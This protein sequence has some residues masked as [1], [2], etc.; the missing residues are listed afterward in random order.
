MFYDYRNK[1][2][3]YFKNLCMWETKKRGDHI[4]IA[5]DNHYDIV[6]YFLLVFSMHI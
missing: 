5:K 6:M 3:S 2:H 4:S 1:A